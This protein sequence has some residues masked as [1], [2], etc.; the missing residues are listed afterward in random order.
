MII[1]IQKQYL[2]ITGGEIMSD[3]YKGYKLLCG[4]TS[5]IND[6]MNNI[7]ADIWNYNE[8]LII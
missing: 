3:F 1:E 4:T 8:Y 7:N 5:D 2:W 6:Y